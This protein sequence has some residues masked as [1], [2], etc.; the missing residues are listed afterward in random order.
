MINPKHYNIELS[1]IV[2]VSELMIG[3]NINDELFAKNNKYTF[4]RVNSV[5]KINGGNDI[6]KQL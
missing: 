3:D 2:E 4:F 1:Y 6:I 5:S